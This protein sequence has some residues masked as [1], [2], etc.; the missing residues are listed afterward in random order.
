LVKKKMNKIKAIFLFLFINIVLTN[1][2]G[3]NPKSKNYK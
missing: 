1:I 2:I 3:L